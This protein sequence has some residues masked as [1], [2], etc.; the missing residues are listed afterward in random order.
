MCD[1]QR[2]LFFV[3]TIT[4]NCSEPQVALGALDLLAQLDS[5]GS[6]EYQDNMVDQVLMDLSD[7]MVCDEKLK[8]FS[9]SLFFT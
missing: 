4:N 3:Y 8:Y 2:V 9:Y 1:I 5:L 7:K 6:L